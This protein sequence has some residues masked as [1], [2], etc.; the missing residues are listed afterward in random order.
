MTEQSQSP[1]KRLA[2][3]VRWIRRIL[4][5]GM[6]VTIALVWRNYE[7]EFLDAERHAAVAGKVRD[8]AILIYTRIDEDTV[9]GEGTLVEAHV[10]VAGSLAD[11]L[12]R[13]E[14]R[15]LSEIRGLPGMVVSW[16][17][18]DDERR[19]IL[20]DGRRTFAVLRV[21]WQEA[22]DASAKIREGPI[23]AGHFLLINP[24]VDGEALD[25]RHVGLVPRA[26]LLRKA[27]WL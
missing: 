3:A 24:A 11:R 17:E 14:G 27:G 15:I 13:T 9:L 16:L 4:I 2:K 8:G 5:V 7:F 20:L 23:P 1:Q 12:G 21:T 25:S 22:L 10:Q 6:V 26:A 18:K 19:E